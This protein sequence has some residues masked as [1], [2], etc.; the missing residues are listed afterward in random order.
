M[1]TSLSIPVILL[2][3]ASG[4][5]WAAFP[6]LR[7]LDEI[8]H[9]GTPS[10]PRTS[11][12]LGRTRIVSTDPGEV[13]FEGRDDDGKGWKAELEVLGGIGFTTVWQADFDHNGRPDLLVA[14]YFPGNGHCANEVALSFLMF[15]DHGRPV[16][17]VI[18]TQM[19][20]SKEFSS[21]PALFVDENHD[22]RAELV[23]A[24]C[25]FSTPPR[26]R[27]GE[28]WRITGIYEGRDARWALMKPGQMD[29]YAALLK[30][31]Y[32]IQPQIDLLLPENPDNWLDRGNTLGT[33]KSAPMELAAVLKP[34]PDCR[35][36]VHLPPLVGGA[37][38]ATD[39]KDPCEELGQNRIHCRTERS[40]TAG[41]PW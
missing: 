18:R 35:G 3:L 37:I 7:Y 28:D 26:T 17:W 34:S 6:G 29:P 36:A 21:V 5:L 1:R 16:P 19:P 33:R 27:T 39:W 20:E 32:R 11:A 22:G 31:T 38:R 25:A 9:L 15:N 8:G 23:V 41:R 13:R 4:S 40:A 2:S 24:G 10:D 30:A 14:A 12:R